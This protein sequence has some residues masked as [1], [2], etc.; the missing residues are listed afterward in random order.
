MPPLNRVLIK[1]VGCELEF[2]TAN[3]QVVE[4]AVHEMHLFD[5]WQLVHDGSCSNVHYSYPDTDEPQL[6]LGGSISHVYNIRK[7]VHGG[8][9]V[10][11]ELETTR[12]GWFKEV[13]DV[14]KI[15]EEAEKGK[16][17]PKSSFHVHVNIGSGW[18]F[19]MRYF[20]NLIKISAYVEDCLYRI[21][22]GSEK[23]HRGETNSYLYCRPNSSPPYTWVAETSNACASFDMN[24]LL[25]TET[26]EDVRKALGRIDR[27]TSKYVPARYV[28]INFV[29]MFTLGSIE[30]RTFNATFNSDYIRTWIELSRHLVELSLND[31]TM[32]FDSLT[33]HPMGEG[34]ITIDEVVKELHIPT[35][36]IPTL[37]ELW[38][39]GS[40]ATPQTP[41]LTHISRNRLDWSGAKKFQPKEVEPS[42]V[43]NPPRH[44]EEGSIVEEYPEDL[45]DVDEDEGE[46]SDDAQPHGQTIYNSIISI[47]GGRY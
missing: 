46:T 35:H 13:A 1:T 32:D 37:H 14:L 3:R 26:P 9:L 39:I 19:P 38:E 41:I 23:N 7:V 25:K 10:S 6:V 42:A 27:T 31:L 29:S 21:S 8:E 2:T 22:C 24:I 34:T 44:D 40:F 33:P 17:D 43:T 4:N 30:F 11:P 36:L 20:H 47:D 28:G 45:I 5:R 15:I 12:N 16:T 18:A